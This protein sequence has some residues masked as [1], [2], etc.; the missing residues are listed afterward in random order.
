MDWTALRDVGEVVLGG[1]VVYGATHVVWARAEIAKLQ[2]ALSS[3][4]LKADLVKVEADAKAAVAEVRGWFV[5]TP[6]AVVPPVVGPVGPSPSGGGSGGIPV[7][8]V[9]VPTPLPLGAP[10]TQAPSSDPTKTPAELAGE[11]RVKAWL[12]PVINWDNVHAPDLSD[13]FKKQ[14]ETAGVTTWLSDTGVLS[15]T[16]SGAVPSPNFEIQSRVWRGLPATESERAYVGYNNA[17]G[18]G[19]HFLVDNLGNVTVR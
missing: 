11:A 13:L 5:N 19:A 2:V 9:V 10:T 14:I 8:Q 1:L 18:I 17:D 15:T 4:A 16:P 12:A 6:P 3:T 7:T